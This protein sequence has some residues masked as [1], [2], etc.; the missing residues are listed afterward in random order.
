MT[1]PKFLKISEPSEAA[2]KTL[3]MIVDGIG[4]H[5]LSE[6]DRDNWLQL[7]RSMIYHERLDAAYYAVE[8]FTNL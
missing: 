2:M 7:G 4:L 5:N 8:H 1:Q 6:E 3:E